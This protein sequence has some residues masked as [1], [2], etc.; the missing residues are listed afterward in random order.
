MSDLVHMHQKLDA[1]GIRL[2]TQPSKS[3]LRKRSTERCRAA[4]AVGNVSRACQQ[5]L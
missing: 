5:K 2:Q 1:R 4:F 3:T